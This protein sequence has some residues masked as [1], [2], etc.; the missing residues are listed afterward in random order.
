MGIARNRCRE[1]R[2]HTTLDHLVIEKMRIAFYAIV[3]LSLVFAC[4][5][6][7]FIEEEIQ[8]PD[9]MEEVSSTGGNTFWPVALKPMKPAGWMHRAA[10]RFTAGTKSVASA[11]KLS[12][13]RMNAKIKAARKAAKKASAAGWA[14]GKKKAKAG[15]KAAKKFAKKFAK[16]AAQMH[17][18]AKAAAKK[19]KAAMPPKP[20][21]K[22][23]KK[24]A[25]KFA[26]K[27]AHMHKKAKAA[28]KKAKAAMHKKAAKGGL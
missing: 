20:K 3:A 4:S 22:A 6:E 16:K 19:A 23:G 7:R 26:K 17:K 13:K 14:W 27:A 2:N 18:K 10:A 9:V 15:K 12:I 28:A 8:V 5:A 25:K 21:A 11:A 24:A 1:A